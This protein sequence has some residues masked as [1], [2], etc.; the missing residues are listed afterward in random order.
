MT[1]DNHSPAASDSDLLADFVSALG[2][3]DS[4]A[5]ECLD[6]STLARALYSSDAS[7]YRVV[8]QVV[9]R[10]RSVEETA[11]LVRAAATVGLPV[12]T[13]GAGT[14]CAGNAI[15]EGLVIDL[16]RHLHTIHSLDP[17]TRTAVVDPGVIQAALQDAGRPHGLRFGPD[18]STS[19][20]C[21]IGGMIGNNACGPRAL[22]YGRTCDNVVSLD[23]L[24]A[25]GDILTVTPGSS[26]D[27]RLAR[28]KA[29]ADANLGVIRTEFG[30]FSRQVSGYQ[31]E[32]LAPEHGFNLPAFFCGTEGTL[33]IVTRATVKLV[34]DPPVG[35]TV[36]LGY[37]S[38]A[39]AADAV[40]ALLP[41]APV[42]CEG[43]DRR[44][45]DVVARAKGA[46]AVPDLPRGDG[47]MFL[48]VR[49]DD[50]TEVADR[51]RRMTAASGALDARVVTDPGEA[52][53][54]W[55]IRSD[56][57]GLA[58]VSL[59]RLAWAGWE[60]A[61]VP[62]ADLG[63]YLRDFED[64]LTA[65]GLRGLPYGH[66]GEGCV[67][68]R[69]DYPL[70]ADDGPEQYRS[71]VADAA[72][73][74]ARHGGSASGEHGDG[75]ARSALLPAMYSPEAISLFGQV[76]GI[77]D[78]DN[79]LNPGVLVNPRPV[80]ADIRVYQARNSPLTLSHP[81]FAHDV[82]QCTGVGKCVAENSPHGGVMCP[83]YQ[84]SHDEKDSTRGRAK[85]LQEMVNGTLVHGWD[86][87]EVTEALDLCLACKGCAR[88][89]PTGIDMAS[90]RSRVLFEKYHRRFRPRSHYVMGWLPRWER[91]LTAV[92]FLASI[93][94]AAL[95]VPGIK[96]LG[97]WVA[98]VDQRRP[99]PTFRPG[100]PARKSLPAAHST[101]AAAAIE[102]GRMVDGGHA[103]AHPQPPVA[104]QPAEPGAGTQVD[105]HGRPAV[106]PDVRHGRVVIWVDSFSDMLGDCDLSAVV[107]VLADAGYQPE[108]L[109]DDV[110]CGLTW[111]TTGQ[112]DGAAKKI[113]KA[114]DVLAPLAEAG[115]P[116]VGLEPSCT[117]VW[118]TDAL[119]LVGDDP[120]TAVVARNVHTMAEMLEAAGWQPPSLAGHVVVAQP[121][122]HHASI[123]GF[124]PDQ[125]LLEASGAQV[126]TVGG[127][128]GY[129]GN[130][131]VEVGHYETSVAVF[132][133]D[134]LPAIEAAGPSAI[135]LADGFSCRRQTSDLTG[136]RAI[137]L[138]ELFA[139]HLKHS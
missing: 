13:R 45:V 100:G 43:M 137:T 115:I 16:A 91:F 90:Y 21:T 122:C 126:R 108:V 83:S 15:G 28:L 107:A 74:V 98:G 6:S 1:V 101:T 88:D 103:A 76:K 52:A 129:A 10:P 8:P 135:I 99:L 18:P 131:G 3:I 54:L 25:A 26:A 46:D 34:A 78:P 29:L 12:T 50:P 94:N 130:F 40:T 75:R 133:H 123:L 92:P 138:A 24:T 109:T 69:I 62:P 89:C 139:S 63:S 95:R 128:C 38:M 27:P 4:G 82:H 71:F 118:R 136:R 111:I 47:W 60:D 37:P 125:R 35:V 124:G 113:R 77:L 17:Q 81:G 97:R 57:A 20:R 134:L 70:D 58:G 112:L 120:R 49:G 114:L 80:E 127:C 44:I 87:P 68:C 41:F 116:V 119:E 65:H 56:G 39:E 59:E 73:L 5:P 23:L 55:Q 53:A 67:H 19:T 96:H 9:A 42:A 51:A 64:L 72:A 106:L 104:L 86:S 132:E 32:H 105:D 102:A 30:T 22:G 84:A 7:I 117:T 66:F 85:V 110:C 36:A 11:A 31:M 33:G 48:D 93:T 2:S 61:A 121:H 79:L 14:S